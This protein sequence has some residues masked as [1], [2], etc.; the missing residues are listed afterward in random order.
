MKNFIYKSQGLI[1]NVYN[2][3]ENIQAELRHQ[4]QDHVI[5]QRDIEAIRLDLNLQ[6]QAD[7]Y[8]DDHKLTH[9]TR[10]TSHQTELETKE[11]LPLGAPEDG[12]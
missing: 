5:L 2:K 10:P 12:Y 11:D 6:R 3:L 9:T 7:S 1:K 4:R 8:Y